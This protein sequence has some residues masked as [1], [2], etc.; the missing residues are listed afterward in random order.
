MVSL[1]SM[2]AFTVIP[3]I[4]SSP[5]AQSIS[6][7]TSCCDTS[8]IR[9]V[10]YPESAVRRAVSESPLR[11]PC[12]ERKYSR[13]SSPSRKLDLMGSSIVRPVVSAMSPRIPASCLICWLE[14]RAPE[15]AI[16]NML[17]YLSSPLIRRSVSSLSVSFQVRITSAYLSSSVIS[18]RR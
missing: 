8:T 5:S 15:S 11:A 7:M 16:M 17:L 2:N 12:A 4:S 6:W 9:R 10:R 14:P 13:T 18:P 1:P 3:G